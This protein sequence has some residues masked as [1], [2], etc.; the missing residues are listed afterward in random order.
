MEFVLTFMLGAIVAT[1]VNNK[2]KRV[3]DLI[4][5]QRIS[6]H[7]KLQIPDIPKPDLYRTIQYTADLLNMIQGS[8]LENLVFSRLDVQ[9]LPSPYFINILKNSREKT[10]TFC[11][12]SAGSANRYIIGFSY[13]DAQQEKPA[14]S[15]R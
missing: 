10:I 11:Y 6:K 4:L 1:L 13:Q 15:C 5:D 2:D 12:D 14:H 8:S 7:I 3:G 9:S